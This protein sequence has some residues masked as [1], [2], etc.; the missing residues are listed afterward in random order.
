MAV[1]STSIYRHV[2]LW[3]SNNAAICHAQLYTSQLAPSTLYACFFL[4]VSFCRPNH[5]LNLNHWSMLIWSKHNLVWP[6]C[7]VFVEKKMHRFDVLLFLFYLVT[8]IYRSLCVAS[9][10]NENI[11]H[12]KKN[13]NNVHCKIILLH[14]IYMIGC[15]KTRS[16]ACELL[17]F[18][19]GFCQDSPSSISSSDKLASVLAARSWMH[20][21]KL[22]TTC[23]K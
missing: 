21:S 9:T 3:Q 14:Y 13:D 2:R 20:E 8:H 17:S 7:L 10:E 4:F 16:R 22:M 12:C 23:S 19:C 18:P 1:L 11:Q 15:L 6:F 5:A